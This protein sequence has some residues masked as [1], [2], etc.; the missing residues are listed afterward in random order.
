LRLVDANIKKIEQSQGEVKIKI[1]KTQQMFSEKVDIDKFTDE[2]SMLASA[3]T[4]SSSGGNVPQSVRA[5]RKPAVG[6]GGLTKQEK[7]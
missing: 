1:D 5:A 7:Q 2:I 3:I 6:A 4:Q